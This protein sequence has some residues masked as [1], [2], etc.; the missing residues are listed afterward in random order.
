MPEEAFDELRERLRRLE[1]LRGGTVPPRG[2]EAPRSESPPPSDLQALAGL[3]EA[4]R[5][6]VPRELSE[7][8]TAVVREVLLL[9]R[10]VLDFYLE[11]LDRPARGEPEV[12]EIPID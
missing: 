9:I 7:Q 4:L 10:A 11:R 1:E 8:L 6:V 5:G 3:I 2:W 12:E